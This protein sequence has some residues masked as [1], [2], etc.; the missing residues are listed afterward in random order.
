[1][2]LFLTNGREIVTEQPF[3]LI[4]PNLVSRTEIS[5]KNLTGSTVTKN[6]LSIQSEAEMNKRSR[7][8]I[9]RQPSGPSSA[10]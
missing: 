2:R 5:A 8:R 6:H 1:M 10:T 4:H 7:Q 3:Y 9:T